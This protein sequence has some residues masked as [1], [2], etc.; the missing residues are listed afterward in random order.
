MVLTSLMR[1]PRPPSSRKK[2]TRAI[3]SQRSAWNTSTAI[4]RTSST[5]AGVSGAGTNSCEP[6]STYLSS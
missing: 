1:N 4:A 2:S 6:S 3:P 5:C